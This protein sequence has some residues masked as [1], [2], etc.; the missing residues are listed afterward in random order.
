MLF[1][2]TLLILVKIQLKGIIDTYFLCMCKYKSYHAEDY[3]NILA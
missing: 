3:Y 2:F 1:P